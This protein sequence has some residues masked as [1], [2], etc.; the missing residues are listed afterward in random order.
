MNP[1]PGTSP[2]SDVPSLSLCGGRGYA[3]RIL[4]EHL[5][6]YDFGMTLYG[7]KIELRP[8][9]KE[10]KPVFFEMATNSDA[11]HWLYGKMYNDEIPTW[12][13]LF[14]DYI[15][16]YFDDSEPEKGRCFAIMSNNTTI[17]QIN[18]NDID[19]SDNSVELDIWI[20]NKCNTGKGYGS[21][22]L[23][24]LMGFLRSELNVENFFICPSVENPRAIKGYQN[25]GFKIIKK[26]VDDKGKEN[27]RME[28]R[29]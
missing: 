17:G 1:L 27:Y 5:F 19:R 3:I 23:Q 14:N 22:A 29:G 18:Y 11:T 13:A 20:A 8:M 4:S 21:D 10:D 25:A 24:T 2:A 9:T 12:Y 6:I 16:H 28:W 15:E 7:K 26:F